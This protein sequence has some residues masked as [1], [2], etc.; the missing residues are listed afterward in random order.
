MRF[1]ESLLEPTSQ[2]SS[3]LELKRSRPHVIWCLE[4]QSHE[5]QE[6]IGGPF[7]TNSISI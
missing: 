7:L 6:L 1:G 5:L 2:T 3:K 4:G